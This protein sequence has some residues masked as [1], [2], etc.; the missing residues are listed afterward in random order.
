MAITTENRRAGPYLGNN[1][2][3]PFPFTFKV[4]FPHDVAA[5]RGTGL[6]INLVDAELTYGVDYT[7]TL[8][9]EQGTSPGG[10]LTLTRPLPPG[11]RIAIVSKVP[12]LQETELTNF[13]AF[14]PSVLN[15]VHDRGV[16]LSQQLR[17][18]LIRCLKAPPTSDVSPD[19]FFQSL[20]DAINRNVSIAQEAA[21]SVKIMMDRAEYAA[22]RAERREYRFNGL[23]VD[24]NAQ[25][26]WEKSEKGE[27]VN[28]LDYDWFGLLPVGAEFYLEGNQ[29]HM[30]A[31]L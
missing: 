14:Y 28:M 13:G 2:T 16:I 12:Y 18:E 29:L 5:Y 21:D 7:V 30:I 1:A 27:I 6:E 20:L 31:L 8:N 24:D 19:E 23:R 17:E 10:T 26:I 3:G 25:L 15:D 9:A 4:F 11:E 22:E